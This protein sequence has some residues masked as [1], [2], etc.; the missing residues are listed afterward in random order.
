MESQKQIQQEDGNGGGGAGGGSNKSSFLCRQSSTRWIPTA[1]QI[2]ILRELYYNNG[3]RS[4]SAE[5]IQ[6]ISARLRQYG[7]IE[8]K[9]VFYWFQNH[10]AR[11][12]QKKRLSTDAA[13]QQRCAAVGWSSCT[14]DFSPKFTSSSTSLLHTSAPGIS[15]CGAGIVCGGQMTGVSSALVERGSF[16]DRYWE[17]GFCS[18]STGGMTETSADS[19]CCLGQH[20]SDETHGADGDIETLQL[21]PLRGGENSEIGSDK[22][23]ADEFYPSWYFGD[24]GGEQGA[25]LELTLGSFPTADGFFLGSGSA[26]LGGFCPGS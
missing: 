21:F 12:R 6:K 1:E 19:Y 5:Q 23:E 17:G 11:E 22:P 8:G 20:D 7:K 25:S 26:G 16:R 2:R 24:A 10:K 15:S 13:V 9:N 3:V 14:D 4:P 18:G